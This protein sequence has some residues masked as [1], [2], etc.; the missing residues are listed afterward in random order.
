MKSL[1]KKVIT[2]TLGLTIAF[3]SLAGCNNSTSPSKDGDDSTN[4]GDLKLSEPGEFPIVNEK[5]RLKVAAEDTSYIGELQTNAFIKWYEEQTNVGIDFD[6]IPSAAVADRINLM[7]NSTTL[8]DMF[9]SQM[10]SADNVSSYGSQGIF[11]DLSDYIE[12]HGHYLTSAMDAVEDLPGGIT[13]ADGGIYS[14]PNI[15]EAFHTMHS[16]RTWINVNW[17]EALNLEKPTTTEEF[18]EVLRAF[19]DND[20]NG[21]GENDEIPMM[22]AS[23][24]DATSWNNSVIPFLLNSFVYYNH[25]SS[26]GTGTGL[27]IDNG[28]IVFAPVEENFKEGLLYIRSLIEEGLIDPTSL[29]QN[30][31]QVL[32]VGADPDIAKIGVVPGATWWSVLGA[33]AYTEDDRS[34]EY[35]GLT[36]LVGPTG[37]NYSPKT[38]TSYSANGLV[39]TKDCKYPEVAFKWADGLYSDEATLRSQAGEEGVEW[40]KPEAGAVGINGKPALRRIINRT[41]DERSASN[42]WMPNIIP[43][44]RTSDWRLGEESSGEW[45]LETRLYN[46]TNEFYI[47][48]ADDDRWFPVVSLTTEESDKISLLR[49]QIKDYVDEQLVMFLAGN[50]SISGE[51]DAYVSE[52]ANLGLEEYLDVLQTAYDRQ[53]K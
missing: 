31:D 42:T 38:G 24:T 50:K 40:E 22:G 26:D 37:I 51:W 25:G 8:P 13:S 1:V 53:Y 18:T 34:R 7:L 4:S 15:N 2:A 16:L 45:D 39:I 30:V 43:A 49:T 41:D 19:R 35:D 11:L 52:Y 23:L 14:L 20:P 12:E 10:I 29:T 3:S 44:N 28:T 46:V 36:T 32:Q 6:E 47:D 33:D 9:I 48:N 5:V 21:N 17:L 27:S